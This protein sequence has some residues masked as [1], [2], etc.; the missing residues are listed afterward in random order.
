[1]GNTKSRT[2]L[3]RWVRIAL[4]ILIFLIFI[5]GIAII[6]KG[7]ELKKVKDK[8][9]P[10]YDYNITQKLDYKVNLNKNSFIE[11]DYLGKNE[12]YLADLI[13]DIY[14]KFIYNFQGTSSIPLKYT[15]QIIATTKGEYTLEVGESKSKVWTKERV[16]LEKSEQIAEQNQ[17][18]I[19]EDITLDF[20]E[21]VE[22][23]RKFRKE[24]NIPITATLNV[25]MKINLIGELSNPLEDEKTISIKIPLNE[26]AFRITEDYE[27]DISNQIFEKN[28]YQG[29]VKNKNLVSGI[30]LI[31][32]SLFLLVLFF[33]EI[34]NVEKKTNYTLKLNKIL[35]SYG[36]IIV[37]LATQ[38][39]MEN[40]Q[41]IDVKNFNEMIDLE[42]ELH[43]PINFYETI[44]SY[45]GEFYLIHSNVIYRYI[46]T[47]EDEK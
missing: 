24:L 9:E 17:L 45:E 18:T 28:E 11:E 1:M 3:K 5:S 14:V 20:Q 26:Q 27:T 8:L 44:D 12:T 47:N 22:E 25:V 31:I 32:T 38:I 29:E 39:N 40:Y 43:I 34:F 2:V 13:K 41:I 35:K 6:I 16:L 4:L 10:I 7:F 37:E 30:I 36:D 33:K 46:L 21:Y 42:E 15:Y 23:V 19:Q